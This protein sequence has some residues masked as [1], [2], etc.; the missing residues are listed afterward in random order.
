MA[1]FMLKN[2]FFEFGTKIIQQIS[3]AATGTRYK[4]VFIYRQN[5]KK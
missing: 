5:K 4:C 3:G 2:N 1:E